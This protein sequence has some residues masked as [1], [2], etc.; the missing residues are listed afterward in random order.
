[1]IVITLFLIRF[2][3][4]REIFS[5]ISVANFVFF[6]FPSGT[7]LSS[8]QLKNGGSVGENFFLLFADTKENPKSAK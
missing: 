3:R 2:N 1:M 6:A 5:H 4:S 7:M 8:K